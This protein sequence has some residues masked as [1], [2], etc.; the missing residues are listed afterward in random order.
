MWAGYSYPAPTPVCIDIAY[1]RDHWMSEIKVE[2]PEAQTR[3]EELITQVENGESVIITRS[4]LPV[5]RLIP[6]LPTP[7]NDR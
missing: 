3:L 5:A 2:I 4:G 1:L 6:V 7:G